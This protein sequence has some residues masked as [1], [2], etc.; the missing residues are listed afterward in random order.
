MP[1]PARV[2]P[3]EPSGKCHDGLRTTADAAGSVRAWCE[4]G[5]LP[6]APERCAYSEYVRA[7]HRPATDGVS[8]HGPKSCTRAT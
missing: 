2:V 1:S 8:V 4:V 5:A 6:G 3:G 7:R